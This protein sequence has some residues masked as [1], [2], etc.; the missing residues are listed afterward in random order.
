MFRGFGSVCCTLD[1]KKRKEKENLVSRQLLS[2]Q[3]PA[4]MRV[5][6]GSLI[7]EGILKRSSSLFLI[8]SFGWRLSRPRR[9]SVLRASVR[10]RRIPPSFFKGSG[11]LVLCW[12]HCFCVCGLLTVHKQSWTICQIFRQRT[13]KLLFDRVS[14]EWPSYCTARRWRRTIAT[15][16]LQHMCSM[17]SMPH[18][19]F[20]WELGVPPGQVMD[21][22]N[23]ISI[24]IL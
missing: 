20:V 6:Y 16:R 18:C 12:F 23:G 15:A 1:G 21:G 14:A 22:M 2:T 13:E 19:L 9:R 11:R 4:F 24:Y 17:W 8:T 7:D 10:G 5:K 3:S